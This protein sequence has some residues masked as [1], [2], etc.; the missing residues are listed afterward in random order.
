MFLRPLCGSS[1]VLRSL[2]RHRAVRAILVLGVLPVL[3]RDDGGFCQHLVGARKCGMPTH[4]RL[5]VQRRRW[6]HRL[7][8]FLACLARSRRDLPLRVPGR[9]STRPS[10][11]TLDEILI[12]PGPVRCGAAPSQ[13]HPSELASIVRKF[14]TSCG[15]TKPNVSVASPD[16]PPTTMPKPWVATASKA[17]S[18]SHPPM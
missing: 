16:A 14:V 1:I 11:L 2:H 6:P 5:L 7:S 13:L 18:S 4:S 8:N 17:S 3:Q 15:A 9:D 10:I 12:P